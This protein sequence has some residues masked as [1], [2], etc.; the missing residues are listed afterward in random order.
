MAS[1]SSK[2]DEKVL[3][4]LQN[5]FINKPEENTNLIFRNIDVGV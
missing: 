1:T 5:I 3:S 4:W 2:E